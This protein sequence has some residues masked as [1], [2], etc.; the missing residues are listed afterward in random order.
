MAQKGIEYKEACLHVLSC[1]FVIF[2]VAEQG[3]QFSV[4]PESLFL[5]PGEEHE[6]VVSFTPKDPKAYEER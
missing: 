6:V 1:G 5:K 3:S 2:Q 4:D